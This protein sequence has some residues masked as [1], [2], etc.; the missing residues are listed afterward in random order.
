[1]VFVVVPL[2]LL[3]TWWQA[4]ERRPTL[5]TGAA[6]WRQ[7]TAGAAAAGLVIAAATLPWTVRN[8]AAFGRFVLL[9]TNAGFAFYW[10]NH[11]I[12]GTR[13][14][15]I[16]PDGAY[17]GLI[18]EELARLDEAALER[19]LMRRAAGFVASD[20]VRFL[21]LSASRVTEYV[22]FWPSRDSGRASN[23]ARVLSFG[24]CL[25]LM[26]AGMILGL[27]GSR[28]RGGD[29]PSGQRRAVWLLL[30]LA[31]VYT[32][33]HVISWT[34]VRYRLPV[35]AVLMPFAGL[36]AVRLWDRIVTHPRDWLE[37]R[38]SI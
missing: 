20:P 36:A 11:P 31:G 23:Y 18:P 25:P 30:G 4:A 16:L 8:Y 5:R 27:S 22:K 6:G 34:L 12:H 32:F 28:H 2:V 14:V 7:A 3:W 15:P 9:N 13:F 26:A 24:V 10:G 21:K 33:V 19:A 35:D 37:K 29:A 17:A 38:A 1:V